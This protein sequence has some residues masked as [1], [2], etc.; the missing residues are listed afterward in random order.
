MNTPR[1]EL[2]YFTGCPHVVAARTVLQKALSAEGM[3][4]EW[5]EWNRDD[6]ATPTALRKY[7]SPTILVD[8]QD[9]APTPADANCCRV[10]AGDDGLRSVPEI[11]T[12]RLALK[13]FQG[14]CQENLC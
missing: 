2:V 10:Y 14:K 13:E 8:G 4:S 5:R 1:V 7:G 9:I 12:I 3:A 11:D 6:A